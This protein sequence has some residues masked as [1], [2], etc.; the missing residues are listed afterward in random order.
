MCSP[1]RHHSTQHPLE[2]GLWGAGPEA[3]PVLRRP[4]G[5]SLTLVAMYWAQILSIP[6][7]SSATGLPRTKLMLLLL[8]HAMGEIS[9]S[10][11]LGD[12]LGGHIESIS[13]TEEQPMQKSTERLGCAT[14]QDGQQTTQHLEKNGGW[15]SPSQKPGSATHAVQIQIYWL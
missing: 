4:M 6:D 1:A 12:G 8:S 15:A 10:S 11:G 13:C 2:E 14:Q 7:A 3:V 5:L 9:C